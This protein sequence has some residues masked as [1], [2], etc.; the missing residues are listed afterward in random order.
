VCLINEWATYFPFD[1]RD[2]KIFDQ[3][4]NIKQNL[5]KLDKFYEKEVNAIQIKLLKE[6]YPEIIKLLK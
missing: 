4:E 6:V 5:S 2:V 1:F 3:I